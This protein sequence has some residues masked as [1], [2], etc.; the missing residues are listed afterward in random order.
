MSIYTLNKLEIDVIDRRAALVAVDQVQR[1]AADALDRGQTQLHR[2]GRDIDRLCSQFQRARIGT[3][4]IF[5]AKRHAAGRRPM[6]LCKIISKAVRLAIED[7]IDIALAI[8]RHV[9]RAVI[10]NLG[11]AHQLERR[12]D[13]IFEQIGHLE[14]SLLC[15]T[16]RSFRHYERFQRENVVKKAEIADRQDARRNRVSLLSVR[17]AGQ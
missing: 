10:G 14:P 4:S 13:G 3:V 1:S 16:C 12:F 11:E 17:P 6:L 8:Q 2:P 5:D 9:F 7:E 15:L